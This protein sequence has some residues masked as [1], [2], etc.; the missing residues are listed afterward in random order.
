[1]R[2]FIAI[3]LSNAVRAEVRPVLEELRQRACGGRF[4]P[5]G[6]THIT[7]QFLGETDDLAGACEAMQCAC[8]GIRPFEIRPERYGFIEKGGRG[9]TAVVFVKGESELD[10]LHETLMSALAD[11]GFKLDL[12]R[13]RP[14]I[15]LGRNVEHDELVL[16]ELA[17]MRF[18][19]S[20]TV[21]GL[22]L[23]ESTRVKGKVVYS[24]LHRQKF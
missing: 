14:H 24:P 11:R 19:S 21:S 18:S 15:T 23:F 20:M 12:K 2:L 7:M 10:V 13:F 9:G 16:S 8:R 6:N 1:M 5:I 3:E 4:V 17:S 22:T